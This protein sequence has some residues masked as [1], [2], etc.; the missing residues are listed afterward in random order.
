MISRDLRRAIAHAVAAAGFPPAR[1]PGL[2]P[3][4]IPGQYAASVAL[5]LGPNP[6]ETAEALAGSLARE[7]WIATAEVTGPGYLTITVTP[8]AL[9]AVAAAITS[10][11]PAC[12]TSDALAGETVPA[13]PA[14]RPAGRRP[15]GKRQERHS[16]RG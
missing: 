9:A 7:P 3:T 15:R 6:R 16:P 4:G 5:T 11:G 10:A 12:V 2:R 14:G 1:D 13:A 8:E